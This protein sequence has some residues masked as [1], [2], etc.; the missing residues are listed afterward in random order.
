MDASAAARDAGFP[1]LPDVGVRGSGTGRGPQ[2]ANQ[3]ARADVGP[4]DAGTACVPVATTAVPLG[5]GGSCAVPDASCYPQPV[6]PAALAWVPPV[7]PSPQ[8]TEAELDAIGSGSVST[9]SEMCAACVET[10]TT[11]SR[12]GAQVDFPQVTFVGYGFA[13]V[14]GCVATLEPC[15][16]PC[17]TL[18]LQVDLCTSEACLPSCDPTSPTTYTAML[19]CLA[20]AQSGCPCGAIVA[21]ADECFNEIVQRQS[22]A[23]ACLPATTLGE[24]QEQA[25]TAELE[26]VA[27]VLCGVR[28]A[29]GG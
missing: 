15:N 11:F 4:R 26:A 3:E 25:Y 16:L 28:S 14:A 12:Y 13:N 20:S 6:P 9:L 27:R 22:P 2:D 19:P 5:D 1:H 24:T 21:A 7:T 23:A 8:C 17:A 29:D 10:E 18:L